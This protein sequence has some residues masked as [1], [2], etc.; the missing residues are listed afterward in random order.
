MK[1]LIV[2]DE[3][4]ICFIVSRILAKNGFTVKYLNRVNSA[5]AEIEENHFDLFLLDLNLPDGTGFDLIP[6][7]REINEDAKIIIISAYDSISEIKKAD[8]LETD[9]FIKKPFSKQQIL[10]AVADL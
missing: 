3:E 9:G 2:D 8:E 1:V 6:Q 4:D 7:I 10:D 5:R